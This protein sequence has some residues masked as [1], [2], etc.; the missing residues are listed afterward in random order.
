MASVCRSLQC[1]IST[2][3]QV[4]RGGLLFR[5]ICSVVLQGG[6]GT[7]D[8]Y[9]CVWVALTVFQPHW[10]CP[11]SRM[12]ALPVYTAQA[13]GSSICSGPCV[14]C[15]SSFPV[16]H[17]SADLVGPAFVPSLV[18]AAQAARGLTGA[19]SLG[20][21]CLLPSAV[22]PSVS[23]RTS[24]VPAACVYSGSWPLATTLLADVDHPE[25]QE[26]FG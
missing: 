23:A 1:L 15:G 11:H 16:L 4:C 10:V 12:Y 2:L 25:S 20:A 9:I 3:T 21:V 8:R 6:R 14:V 7:A 24:R 5:F 18:R 13:P 17:K 22:P 26:V 19:L